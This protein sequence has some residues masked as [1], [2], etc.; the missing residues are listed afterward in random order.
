MQL[1]LFSD[2][3]MPFIRDRLIP[4]YGFIED[5]V[6]YDPTEQFVLS[7]ISSQK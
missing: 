6:R 7:L 3:V 1:S 5:E 4:L 2:P